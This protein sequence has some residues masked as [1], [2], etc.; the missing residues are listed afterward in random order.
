[1]SYFRIS[2]NC[3]K[4]AFKRADPTYGVE[5][6]DFNTKELIWKIPINGPSLTGIE[7]SPDDKYLV[8][9]NGPGANCL[10]I[11]SMENGEETH[12]YWPRS[13]DFVCLSNNGNYVVSGL[14]RY[15]FKFHSRFNGIYVE[16]SEDTT[17]L[18]Y[19]NPTNGLINLEFN[20]PI[21]ENT[22]INLNDINGL[23]IKNLF[24]NIL[25]QGQQSINFNVSDLS[26]GTYYIKVNNS[27]LS[28]FFKLIINK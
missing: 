7:F 14:G 21:L 20:N 27:Q 17:I 5:V 8:T 15:L 10:K 11:W 26:N 23:L 22:L 19:P 24:N 12:R 16:P 2:N 6:Y 28:L 25:E 18:I 1:M 3:Q 4:I 9:S 13:Y